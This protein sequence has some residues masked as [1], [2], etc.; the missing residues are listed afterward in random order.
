VSH[1]LEILG[2]MRLAL[3]SHEETSSWWRINEN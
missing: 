3:V 1:H 2:E